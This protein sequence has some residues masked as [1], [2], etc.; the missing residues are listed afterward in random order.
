ML[1]TAP[2]VVVFAAVLAGCGSSNRGASGH[3]TGLPPAPPPAPAGSVSRA[4]ILHD[5]ERISFH[6]GNVFHP[7]PAR[8]KRAKRL[9]LAATQRFIADLAGWDVMPGYKIRELDTMLIATSGT[10]CPRCR[11]ALRAARDLYNR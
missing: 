2:L 5:E 4:K 7:I 6:G 3:T 10:P 8:A 9:M 11:A 1:K